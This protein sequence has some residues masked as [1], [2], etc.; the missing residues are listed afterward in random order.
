MALS[1]SRVLIRLSSTQDWSSQDA[2]Q[3]ATELCGFVTI[4]AGTFLLH[5]TKDMGSSA[6]SESE[7]V[8]PNR[9]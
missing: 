5:K 8:L 1:L 9:A 4:L 2:A 6:P 3:I 7:P